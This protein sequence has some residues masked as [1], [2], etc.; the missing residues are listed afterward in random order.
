MF[1]GCCNDSCTQ[2][3][4]LILWSMVQQ[5][6]HHVCALFIYTLVSL[7][8]WD[9][10]DNLHVILFSYLLAPL[11]VLSFIRIYKYQLWWLF[12]SIYLTVYCFCVRN[13][14]LYRR[15][16][17]ALH[18]K[19]YFFTNYHLIVVLPILD[20]DD[21]SIAPVRH[22]ATGQYWLS[23]FL[24]HYTDLSRF[25]CLPYYRAVY[26]LFVCAVSFLT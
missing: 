18:F 3:V 13:L 6:G 24:Q 22:G 14:I 16:I 7:A 10:G 20:Y 15:D 11:V 8:N 21:S 26:M 12:Y 25:Y 4:N 1:L 9:W 5:T 23:I 2:T 19:N 17:F